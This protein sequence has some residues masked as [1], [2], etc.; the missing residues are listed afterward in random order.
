MSELTREHQT[1]DRDTTFGRDDLS[2]KCFSTTVSKY[3][4][5]KR[6]C[7][8]RQL[9]KS[10]SSVG[11][12]HECATA[13]SIFVKGEREGK[14]KSFRL[15]ATCV[16]HYGREVFFVDGGCG[17]TKFRAHAWTFLYRL[18]TVVAPTP[19]SIIIGFEWPLP[20]L[21][22]RVTLD[23]NVICIR[24]FHITWFPYAQIYLTS[25]KIETYNFSVRRSKKK[26]QYII[27][28]AKDTFYN[29]GYEG[30]LLVLHR[31]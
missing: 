23:R 11:A 8:S 7:L 19:Q 13:D 4:Y 16:S 17:G 20:L 2:P 24:T 3:I 25:K 5:E 18:S 27:G 6:I 14:E 10:F 26:T 1:P 31:T 29:C 9:G 12:V 15:S 22:D 28:F 21:H 30:N